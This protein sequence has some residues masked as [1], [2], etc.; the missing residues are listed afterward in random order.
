MRQRPERFWSR[1]DISNLTLL[2][3][4]N[5]QLPRVGD[6]LLLETPPENVF[7][8]HGPSGQG[9]NATRVETFVICETETVL[10]LLWQ[11]CSR[12]R[13]RST[14]VIPYMNPDEYDCW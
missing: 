10:D 13:V 4:V 14:D 11:D 12:E 1:K 8:T 9:M 5:D 6:R 2:R 3:G 7:T